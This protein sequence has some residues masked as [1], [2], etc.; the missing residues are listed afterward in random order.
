MTPA[1]A[2]T[3]RM[4][5]TE[6][7]QTTKR[8]STT[9]EVA[10][11]I[12]VRA[13][14]PTLIMAC[15]SMAQPPMPPSMP[16]ARFETPRPKHSRVGLPGVFVIS[17]MRFRVISDSSRPTAAMRMANG[18]TVPKAWENEGIWYCVSH[19]TSFTNEPSRAATSLTRVVLLP[20]GRT[21]HHSKAV[22]SAIA[23]RAEGTRCVSFGRKRLTQNEI[24]VMI[25][26]K[27]A[28]SPVTK[29]S[30]SLNASKFESLRLP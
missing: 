7:R 12:R 17:S 16:Q 14:E 22:P 4:L 26:A 10:E 30:P 15:P 2:E 29:G 28:I 9:P 1:S 20:T 18:S 27:S 5:I 23:T 25:P 3:G 24:A 13:P 21:T 8:S 19:H 6:Y 11:E